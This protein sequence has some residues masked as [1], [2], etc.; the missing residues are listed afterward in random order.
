MVKMV[1]AKSA[2]SSGMGAASKKAPTKFKNTKTTGGVK[3]VKTKKAAH[4]GC[5]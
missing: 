2:K 5:K 3:L 1:K 4:M